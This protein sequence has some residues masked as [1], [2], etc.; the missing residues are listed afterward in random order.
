[1]VVESLPPTKHVAINTNI[2]W[3]HRALSE[4]PL[5]ITPPLHHEQLQQW[6]DSDAWQPGYVQRLETAELIEILEEEDR[7]LQ[8]T[9]NA[10]EVQSESARELHS[11]VSQQEADLACTMEGVGALFSLLN[12]AL[13]D[14]SFVQ[15]PEA[16]VEVQLALE[17]EVLGASEGLEGNKGRWRRTRGGGRR[18]PQDISARVRATPHRSR[19]HDEKSWVALD[20]VM[21]PQLY[22]HVTLAEAEE[23]RWD[24]LY[25]TRL[26]REDILRIMSLPPQV[27]LALPFLH[28]PHEVA[29]HELLMRYSLGINAEYFARLDKNS[30]DVSRNSITA[31]SSSCGDQSATPA[32][33][34]AAGEKRDSS[35][36]GS[37]PAARGAPAQVGAEGDLAGATHRVLKCM[38]RAAMAK[39]KLFGERDEDEAIWYVLDRKLHPD[40]YRESDEA[41]ADRNE[42]LHHEVD[43]REDARHAWLAK[44]E[45]ENVIKAMDTTHESR[46]AE[47]GTNFS[48]VVEKTRE[49]DGAATTKTVGH[50]HE[51]IA[52]EIARSYSSGYIK[53]LAA[54]RAGESLA[55]IEEQTVRNQEEA[56]ALVTSSTEI[57]AAGN[58]TSDEDRAFREG[59][60]QTEREGD[61][62][63]ETAEEEK[64]EGEQAE[65]RR[66]HVDTVQRVLSLFLVAEEETPLGR[67]MTRSLAMLQEVT[68][69]LIGGKRNIFSG[70][71]PHT[72]LAAT[73][74]RTLTSGHALPPVS[75]PDVGGGAAVVTTH[76]SAAATRKTPAPAARGDGEGAVCQGATAE[77]V[78]TASSTNTD[79]REIMTTSVLSSDVAPRSGAGPKIQRH[80][81]AELMT[82]SD[83]L[84][85]PESGA[86]LGSESVGSVGGTSAMSDTPRRLEKVFGSWEE[87]HPAAL[88]IGSQ[89]N[90]FS[91]Q[92]GG[93]E[94]AEHPASFRRHATNQGD[95]GKW[96][97]FV[98]PK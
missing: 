25:Y 81:Q 17:H 53:D 37:M 93:G 75:P 18:G 72:A 66:R 31:S 42:A 14:E 84:L 87:V 96:Q 80:P 33:A 24:A 77:R 11:K 6:T 4:A 67:D 50:D 23:M 28:T 88:G 58:G 98:L 89:E 48:S 2:L 40:L 94:N 85:L 90:E 10:A 62:G 59:E 7:K 44:S 15:D 27:Q 64:K 51:S 57:P 16:A 82:S 36:T 97:N 55:D 76:V 20:A 83:A 9:A 22:H 86:N 19:T 1:M 68:L 5:P 32:E 38:R 21:S 69:R 47:G 95:Y 54:G 60:S 26:D 3:C 46:A 45:E 35:T 52:E 43:A 92:E 34:V 73:R 39:L 61:Y 70:L 63:G 29:A 56:Q 12:S 65:Q 41:A 30:Q 13:E 74:F 71:N 49:V 78:L 8:S 79:S 91:A